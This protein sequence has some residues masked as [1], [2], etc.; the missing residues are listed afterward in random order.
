MEHK[1]SLALQMLDYT[2]THSGGQQTGGVM[3]QMDRPPID[4]LG[5]MREECA[6]FCWGGEP[7]GEHFLSSW[8]RQYP[9]PQL[10]WLNAR[11]HA[12]DNVFMCVRA[13][14]RL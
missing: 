9:Q 2:L 6:F 11:H 4:K 13:E 1:N 12:K 8:L 7:G 14:V 3:C 10:G 5:V